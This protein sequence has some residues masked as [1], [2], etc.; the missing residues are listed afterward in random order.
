MSAFVIQRINNL[1][2]NNKAL[3][4]HY[5]IHV[6]FNKHGGVLRSRVTCNKCIVFCTS[7]RDLQ[8]VLSLWRPTL[9][10]CL[11]LSS[12]ERLK[13]K[14]EMTTIPIKTNA[15]PTPISE[16]FPYTIKSFFG[17]ATSSLNLSAFFLSNLTDYWRKQKITSNNKICL[18]I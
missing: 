14:T 8:T 16:Y 6:Y 2:S 1:S 10:Y 17:L 15:P 11:P 9:P 12:S 18:L 5:H 4:H 7:P 13:K 3:H